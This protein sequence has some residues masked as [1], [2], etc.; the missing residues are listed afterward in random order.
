MAIVLVFPFTTL[1]SERNKVIKA[2]IKPIVSIMIAIASLER[3]FIDMDICTIAEKQ[4]A[5]NV[6]KNT[7]VFLLLTVLL[8][9]S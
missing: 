6:I 8:F 7:I 2:R 4:K 9:R 1:D 3:S 5:E